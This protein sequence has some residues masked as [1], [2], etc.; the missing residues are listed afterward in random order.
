MQKKLAAG[1]VTQTEEML[2]QR[3]GHM[4]LVG[5]GNKKKGAKPL[6]KGGTKKFG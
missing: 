3:A 5:K 6:K 2:G 1:L 4:E